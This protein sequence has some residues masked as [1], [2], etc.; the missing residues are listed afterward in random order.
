MLKLQ[1]H[2]MHLCTSH[3]GLET[4]LSNLSRAFTDT[5]ERCVHYIHNLPTSKRPDM[6]L[7]ISKSIYGSMRCEVGQQSFARCNQP[8]F[9]PFTDTG[10]L[11]SWTILTTYHMNLLLQ[12]FMSA[13]R[14]L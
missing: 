6:A 13:N 14:E 1:M 2:T 5:A 7:I 11:A 4:V 12:W 10:R 3:N 8:S 9:V